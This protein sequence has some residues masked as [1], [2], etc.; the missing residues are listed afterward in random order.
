MRAQLVPL[1]AAVV[2]AAAL[3][4]LWQSL[5][6]GFPDDLAAPAQH[7]QEQIAIKLPRCFDN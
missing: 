5:D 7:D 2:A 6:Y 4:L 3:N 1:L